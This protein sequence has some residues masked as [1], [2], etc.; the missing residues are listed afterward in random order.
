MT[1]Y[2]ALMS[3]SACLAAACDAVGIQLD[4]CILHNALVDAYLTTRLFLVLDTAASVASTAVARAVQ[5]TATRSVQRLTTH[6]H[7]TTNDE[8]DD[9]EPMSHATKA[10]SD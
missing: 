5:V 7:G 6:A 8:F 9:D 1:R 10:A 3:G 2:R 4:G